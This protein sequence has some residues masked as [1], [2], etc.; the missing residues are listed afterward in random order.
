MIP[1]PFSFF[2]LAISSWARMISGLVTNVHSPF[3]A[4]FNQCVLDRNVVPVGLQK[5]VNFVAS[6]SADGQRAP[7][8]DHCFFGE[9]D[10]VEAGLAVTAT[11]RIGDVKSRSFAAFWACNFHAASL[12]RF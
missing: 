12:L 1:L 2:S 4:A 3:Y 6:K 7:G 5:V 11:D 9:L 8:S 10:F